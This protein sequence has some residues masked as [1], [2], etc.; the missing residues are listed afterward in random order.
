[1]KP[2]SQHAF[3]LALAAAAFLA[4]VAATAFIAMQLDDCRRD[5]QQREEA[6][7]RSWQSLES[8]IRSRARGVQKVI[9]SLRQIAAAVPWPPQSDSLKRLE[10]AVKQ[11]E[12]ATTPTQLT[13]A[14]LE[15]I[16]RERQSLQELD[17]AVG[18][19]HDR[20]AS[21][22]EDLRRLRE[23]VAVAR[24]AYNDDVQSLNTQLELFPNNFAAI[25]YRIER[26]EDYFPVEAMESVSSE[27]VQ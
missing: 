12:A 27:A 1:M 26:R 13:E 2:Q 20:L 21:I 8:A 19:V 17:R 14:H 25:V 11:L 16:L 6:I 18:A 3:S 9:P 10:H 23:Q 4:G 5:L 7:E 22:E 24:A 15:S